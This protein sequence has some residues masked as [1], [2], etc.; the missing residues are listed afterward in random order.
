MELVSNTYSPAPAGL[1]EEDQLT[2]E[3]PVD[4]TD[5][6]D[7]NPTVQEVCHHVINSESAHHAVQPTSGDLDAPEDQVFE[8][9]TSAP[10]PAQVA[11]ATRFDRATRRSL[12]LLGRGKKVMSRC[13]DARWDMGHLKFGTSRRRRL[14]PGPGPTFISR[15]YS[16]MVT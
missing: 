1:T 6:N 11:I 15:Q 14:G 13:V 9:S 3:S 12:R 5:D 16:S 2:D 7:T 4:R 10:L 8:V